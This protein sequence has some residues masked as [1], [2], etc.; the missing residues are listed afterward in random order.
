MDRNLYG[1]GEENTMSET[2]QERLKVLELLEKGKIG[3]EEAERLLRA[4]EG[5]DSKK[6]GAAEGAEALASA[7]WKSGVDRLQNIARGIGE[8]VVTMVA[9]TFDEVSPLLPLTFEG[10]MRLECDEDGRFRLEPHDEVKICT[11]PLPAAPGAEEKA[12]ESRSDGEESEG[13]KDSRRLV[14]RAGKE[15]RRGRIAGTDGFSLWRKGGKVLLCWSSGEL[16]VTL[17]AVRELEVE[18]TGCKIEVQPPACDFVELKL[19]GGEL[20][21]EKLSLP[22]KVKCLGG[23]VTIDGFS[24]INGKGS[25]KLTGGR[26]EIKGLGES[27]APA[28]EA[29]VTGGNIEPQGDLVQRLSLRSSFAGAKCYLA[30]MPSTEGTM[31]RSGFLKV[32]VLGGKLILAP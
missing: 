19:V 6:A 4:L 13:R 14:I 10:Y 5:E 3:V 7:T 8:S 20:H 12:A 23:S 2:S 26:V 25:V 27:S 1:A 17:P 28:L 22:C 16:D 29:K 15:K 11:V 31:D 30:P 32:K 24:S 9:D 18:V 21:V